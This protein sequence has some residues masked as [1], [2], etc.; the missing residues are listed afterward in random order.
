MTARLVAALAAV[1]AALFLSSCTSPASDDH[2]N[3]QPA[4]EPVIT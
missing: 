4:D 3:N 1:A 2:T